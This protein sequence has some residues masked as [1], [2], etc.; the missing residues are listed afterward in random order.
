L[1]QMVSLEGKLR[2]N[3]APTKDMRK[4]IGYDD[5]NNFSIQPGYVGV[6]RA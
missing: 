5:E 3:R 2:G 6:G 1:L 4:V